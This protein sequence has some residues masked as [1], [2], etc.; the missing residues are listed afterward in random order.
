MMD[1]QIKGRS[2]ILPY[3]NSGAAYVEYD[4]AAIDVADTVGASRGYT[5]GV[6]DK[7]YAAWSDSTYPDQ[8]LLGAPRTYEVAASAR[9]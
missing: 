9:W 3:S 8:I 2:P 4:R 6:T 7:V 5:P 1:A